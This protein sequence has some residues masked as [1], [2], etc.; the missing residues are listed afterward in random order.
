VAASVFCYL[1]QV[2]FWL[3]AGGQKTTCACCNIKLVRQAQVVP[4]GSQPE[5]QLIASTHGNTCARQQPGSASCIPKPTIRSSNTTINWNF[6]V[7][8]QALITIPANEFKFKYL[9]AGW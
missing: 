2:F 8:T 4:W 6:Y 5:S 1:A 9:R 7:N 3:T